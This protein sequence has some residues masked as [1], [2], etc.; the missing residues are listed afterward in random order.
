MTKMKIQGFFF[1]LRF[2]LFPLTLSL[3][4]SAAS[5]Q[6]PSTL[7]AQPLTNAVLVL[8]LCCLTLL[9]PLT[10]FFLILMLA[11]R[12]L[13]DLFFPFF[14]ECS[15]LS[16]P[17]FLRSADLLCT[18]LCKERSGSLVSRTAS[19]S[20]SSSSAYL[21]AWF[22]S[23]EMIY[24]FPMVPVYFYFFLQFYL[25]CNNHLEVLLLLLFLSIQYTFTGWDFIYNQ[26]IFS[27]IL[28]FATMSTQKTGLCSHCNTVL[29]TF[30]WLLSVVHHV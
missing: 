14:S 23:N 21:K 9:S 16:V 29:Q 18:I 7:V 10:S 15:L 20:I 25:Q 3:L 26:L 28:H 11:Y 13:R 12:A 5:L 2:A 22:G 27:P 19:I 4:N 30:E 1:F 24:L 6:P 17:T 8:V